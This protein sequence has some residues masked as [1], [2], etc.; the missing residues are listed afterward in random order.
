MSTGDHS[1]SDG[2]TENADS[3]LEDT[4]RHFVGPCQRDWDQHLA[5]V[6]FAMTNSYHSGI[7]NTPFALNHG[8]HPMHP[9]PVG[10]RHKNPAVSTF[11]GDREEQVSKA[12]TFYTIAQQRYEQYADKHRRPSPDSSLEIKSS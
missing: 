1:Q 11:L 2:Q 10:L 3:N 12:K 7:R 4:L 5:V 8:Q 9:V 6:E